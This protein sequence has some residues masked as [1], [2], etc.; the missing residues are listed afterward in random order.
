MELDHI[1]QELKKMEDEISN[2]MKVNLLVQVYLLR[3]EKLIENLKGK[4][5]K[6]NEMLEGMEME[7]E[8][9]YEFLKDQ[10][11]GKDNFLK[12]L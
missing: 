1:I 2:Q 4:E 9:L 7:D 8:E 3:T 12:D 6:L 11:H 10:L 5:V